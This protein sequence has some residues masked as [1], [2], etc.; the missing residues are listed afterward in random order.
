MRSTIKIA[1]AM[2]ILAHISPATGQ[3]INWSHCSDNTSLEHM[4]PHVAASVLHPVGP[5]GRLLASRAL[6]SEIERAR[7]LV[8][9]GTNDD[10]IRY[11][12]TEAELLEAASSNAT[13]IVHHGLTESETVGYR[14][15]IVVF[16]YPLFGIVDKKINGGTKVHAENLTNLSRKLTEYVGNTTENTIFIHGREE[17]FRNAQYLLRGYGVSVPDSFR[18]EMPETYEQLAEHA[19]AA[20]DGAIVVGLRP[21]DLGKLEKVKK[22]DVLDNDGNAISLGRPISLYIREK[23]AGSDIA[24]IEW[25]SSAVIK[26]IEEDARMGVLPLFCS[27]AG[28]GGEGFF[29]DNTPVD[30]VKKFREYFS[31]LVEKR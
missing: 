5:R 18:T 14:K 3:E 6:P 13:L 21:S 2:S 1:A 11:S 10:G 7:A 17:N 4:S 26:R 9:S 23:N 28:Q 27:D 30:A 12:F 25:Y 20:V 16:E 31:E 29:A 15:S 24:R 19:E 22:M 8:S